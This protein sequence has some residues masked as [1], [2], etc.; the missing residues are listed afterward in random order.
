[1]NLE[2]G[3]L[4][5]NIDLPC[6]VIE[7]KELP[8]M[9]PEPFLDTAFRKKMP[10]PTGVITYLDAVE[11]APDSSGMTSIAM[12]VFTKYVEVRTLSLALNI[13]NESITDLK[14]IYNIDALEMLKDAIYQNLRE[15]ISKNLY[16]KYKEL[17]ELS[18]ISHLKGY[19]KKLEDGWKLSMDIVL[20][21]DEELPKRLGHKIISA[22]NRIGKYGR[23]GP[24]NF[25]I[26]PSKLFSILADNPLFCY[27]HTNDSQFGLNYIKRV[28]SFT[29]LQVF[30]NPF[31]TQDVFVVGRTTGDNEPGVFLGEYSCV[32]RK[33]L[34]T[35]P[36]GFET[37][38]NSIVSRNRIIELGTRPEAQYQTIKVKLSSEVS[39]WK[40]TLLKIIKGPVL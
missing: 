11:E 23:R 25:V 9:V 10:A 30:I 5:E 15:G 4:Q 40:K 20:K 18:R 37:I 8:I 28:G 14:N 16:L 1:M 24:G 13:N 32:L 35:D 17:G 26:L 19:Q 21:D 31:E 33:T 7:E 34:I 3:S 29:T 27:T 12:K 6:V 36:S 39:L 38:K 2:Q 22:A